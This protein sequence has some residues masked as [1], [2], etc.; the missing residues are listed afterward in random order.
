MIKNLPWSLRNGSLIKGKEWKG[1]E[2]K[3]D[4]IA[5]ILEEKE[6]LWVFLNEKELKINVAN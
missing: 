1:K 3:S 5:N 4:M 6:I 2:R